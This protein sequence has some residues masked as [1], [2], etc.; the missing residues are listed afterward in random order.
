MANLDHDAI[1]KAYSEVTTI[2]DS[3]GAF[4]KDGNSVT[5]EQSKID[6]A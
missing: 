1:R 3:Q 6:A 5:L 4:D 2:Q